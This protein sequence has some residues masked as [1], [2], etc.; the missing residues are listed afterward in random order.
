M[1][2]AR[3]PR[4][5]VILPVRIRMDS[6]WV[7]ATIRNISTK[8]MKLH[9]PSPPP[10][11]S[12]IEIRRG[13]AVVVGQV[14]WVDEGCCGLLAQG[15][16]PVAQFKGAPAPGAVPRFGECGT[17]VERRTSARILTPEEVAERSRLKAML[18]QKVIIAAAG[19]AG[20]GFIGSLM[21]GALE[22]PMAAI[23]NR[24]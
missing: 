8:G 24:L 5:P 23:S 2:K 9:M 19:I 17:E 21:Y 3:E 15:R 14:R 11:G 20:A 22:K 1:F 6:G 12:F 10:R 4:E 7:D 16:V 13:S 18:M